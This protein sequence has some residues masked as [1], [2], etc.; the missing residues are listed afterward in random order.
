[1]DDIQVLLAVE[2]PMLREALRETIRR[3]PIL[4]MVGEV[5]DPVDLLVA[6]RQTQANVVIMTWPETDGVPGVCSHLL[7][8]FPELVVIGISAT[9]D[10]V[11]ACRQTI[12]V[13]DLPVAGLRDLLSEIC[14]AAIGAEEIHA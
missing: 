2:S 6:V 9:S 3:E 1:V 8:E 10:R 5:S 7:L 14:N 4:N 12:T 11:V 13:S